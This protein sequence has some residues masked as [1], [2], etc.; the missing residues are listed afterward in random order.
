MSLSRLLLVCFM[1]PP[2]KWFCAAHGLSGGSSGQ[3]RTSGPGLTTAT[4]WWVKLNAVAGESCDCST[5]KAVC[6]WNTAKLIK[7]ALCNDCNNVNKQI[8]HTL[9]GLFCCFYFI[10]YSLWTKRFTYC[11]NMIYIYNGH[12]Q[13]C[14]NV[15][16]PHDPYFFATN[17]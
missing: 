9:T 2:D 1:V 4:P 7:S 6:Y 16:W 12:S 17:M 14:L 13:V 10:L 5:R 15:W 8:L 3:R 11:V